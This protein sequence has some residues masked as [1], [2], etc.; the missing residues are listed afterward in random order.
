M[1]VRLSMSSMFRPAAA[2]SAPRRAAT[3]S[4][5][6]GDAVPR[7]IATPIAEPLIVPTLRRHEYDAPKARHANSA[8]TAAGKRER[9]R[10]MIREA[11]LRDLRGVHADESI[12][13][14]KCWLGD[15]DSNQD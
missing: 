3:V 9:A 4:A 13:G 12:T 8:R 10:L 7:L 15:L 2:A 5:T 11:L 14:R 6:S 1:I